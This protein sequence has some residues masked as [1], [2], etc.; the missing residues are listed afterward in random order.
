MRG[1]LGKGPGKE[2][3]GGGQEGGDMAP[4]SQEGML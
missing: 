2:G 3:S 4:G 1:S